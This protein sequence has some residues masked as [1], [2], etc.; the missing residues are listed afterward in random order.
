MMSWVVVVLPKVVKKSSREDFL[1]KEEANQPEDEPCDH[2]AA[3]VVKLSGGEEDTLSTRSAGL[4][5]MQ[6]I[7]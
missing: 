5:N 6:S 7:F 4:K 2:G 3:E 1:A